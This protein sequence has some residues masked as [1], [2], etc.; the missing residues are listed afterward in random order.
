MRLRVFGC[1][2]YVRRLGDRPN[3]AEYHVNEG[4]FLGYTATLDN[5]LYHN[6]GTGRM[7]KAPSATFDEASFTQPT[8]TPGGRRLAQA[9]GRDPSNF[10]S[11]TQAID[12]NLQAVSDPYLEK[13]SLS[14]TVADTRNHGFRFEFEE[15]RS[16]LY[17]SDATMNSAAAR[18]MTKRKRIRHAWL[19]TV[20]GKRIRTPLD[21]TEA[22]N[23]LQDSSGT[24]IDP[25]QTHVCWIFAPDRTRTTNRA[26][27]GG[28]PLLN[29]DQLTRVTKN[30]ERSLQ[31]P[32]TEQEGIHH[33]LTHPPPLPDVN[34]PY[35]PTPEYAPCP[36]TAS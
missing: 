27:L 14:M 34:D 4:F 21:I 13:I 36:A 3:K 11:S 7:A 15:S 18:H 25:T 28:M 19:L 6:T 35:A 12:L 24:L 1:K 29:I 16:R 9:T 30:L 23:E 31:I 22:I 5:I 2:V 33:P 17:V 26:A 8:L 10:K 20:N 32:P